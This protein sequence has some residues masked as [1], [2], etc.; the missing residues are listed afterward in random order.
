MSN[1]TREVPE[2]SGIFAA[3]DGSDVD[4]SK[5]TPK[6]DPQEQSDWETTRQTDQPWK[7]IPEKEQFR[8]DRP[9][10]DLEK[11]KDTNAH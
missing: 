6:D 1:L 3:A 11:W 7:G 2:K 8:T 4:M 9:K 5:E 10:P